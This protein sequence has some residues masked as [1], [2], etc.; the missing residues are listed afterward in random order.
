M[1][2]Q[3]D[4]L[5]SIL[6]PYGLTVE[7]SEIYL[8]LLE[9]S[10][11]TALQ[12]SRNLHIGRTKVYRLLDK[13]IS[14]QLIIQKLKDTGLTFLASPP[15]TLELLLTKKEGE[16][17]TLRS[18]L[19]KIVSSLESQTQSGIQGSQTLYYRGLSGL[20]QVNWN[21]CRAKG[22]FL[23]YEVDNAEAYLPKQEAE[24][25]RSRLVEKKV[26]I[27]TITNITE[28]KPFTNIDGLTDL[29]QVKQVDKKTLNIKADIFIYNNV[30][31]VVNY[32]SK[33]DIFCVEIYNQNLADMQRQLFEH[34]WI[35]AK[36]FKVLDDHGAAILK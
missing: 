2:E 19:P 5:I 28:F 3:T 15:S 20:S 26:K 24:D 1:S 29:W 7:E 22:E 31:T 33:K 21:L 35:S 18:N 36:K 12:L 17:A 23:S 32:L 8:E 27:R 13:L 16:L 11:L 34:L 4:N 25:L 14:K 10:S 6:E 9:N 30:Y